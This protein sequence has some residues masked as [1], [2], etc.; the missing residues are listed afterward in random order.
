[1]EL[2]R[3]DSLVASESQ[4]LGFATFMTGIFVSTG[5]GW[6]STPT[7]SSK[8]TAVYLTAMGSSLIMS[9]WFWITWARARRERPRLLASVRA[10]STVAN[11]HRSGG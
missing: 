10:R 8:E 2:E 7:P 1:M 5:T 9:A 6:L 11:D 4:A 3:L